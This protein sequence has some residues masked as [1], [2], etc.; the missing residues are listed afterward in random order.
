M[1]DMSTKRWLSKNHLALR[2]A[3]LQP[4]RPSFGRFPLGH[5]GI[6]MLRR[7]FCMWVKIMLMNN[8]EIINKI[9]FSKIKWNDVELVPA[10]V[11]DYKDNEILMLAFMNKESLALTLE[12]KETYFYSRSRNELW[13]KGHKSGEVQKVKELYYDCDNDT[14]LV[15]VEQIGGVACHTGKRSCFF[16]R[17]F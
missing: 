7:G 11:Q 9:D 16:N 14:I 6:A 15:K 5:S 4:Q 13:H 8:Q 3:F 10:I 17:G 12:K 2:I 1:L